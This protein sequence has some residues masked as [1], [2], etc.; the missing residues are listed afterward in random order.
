MRPLT[1]GE[2]A[3]FVGF[4]ASSDQIEAL[5]ALAEQ[6]GMS[7]SAVIRA[8]LERELEEAAA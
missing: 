5:S 3:K 6:R 8:A 1:E 4:K 7:M 2:R